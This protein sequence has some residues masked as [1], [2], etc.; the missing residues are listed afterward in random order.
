MHWAK[1]DKQ[2]VAIILL[3]FEKAYNRIEW[4]FIRGMLQAF[5]FPSYFCRWIYILFKDS[6]IVIEVNG[7]LFEP[8]PLKRSI[9]QGCPIALTLFAI[10]TDAL[11]Y[12]LRAP[13]LG[14]PIRGLTLPNYEDLINAQF[15]DDTALFLV[16]NEEKFDNAM[17]RL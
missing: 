9:R 3:D 14:P 12:I 7:E 4:P 6:S 1:A 16:L 5:G 13:A 2:N 11:F 17:N 10:T 15:A 8:I